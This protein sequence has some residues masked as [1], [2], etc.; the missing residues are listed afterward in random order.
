MSPIRNLRDLDNRVDEIVLRKYQIDLPSALYHYTSIEAAKG[1]IEG[2]LFW[3][4]HHSSMDDRS[5]L[6]TATETI[7]AVAQEVLDK[8]RE[9]VRRVLRIFVENYEALK[10]AVMFDSY[11]VCFTH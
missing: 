5:E 8:S 7:R 6:R 1:I 10:T 2:Q 9:P 3:A 11:L 4:T